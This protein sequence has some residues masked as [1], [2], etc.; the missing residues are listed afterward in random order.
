MP[1]RLS[2]AGAQLVTDVS[3]PETYAVHI[4]RGDYL[5]KSVAGAISLENY[6]SA[7]REMGVGAESLV[8][9]FTDSLEY[10]RE[11]FSR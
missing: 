4:S 7:L 5:L 10:V 3:K 9:V 6:I 11:A 2:R 1:R 8:Y